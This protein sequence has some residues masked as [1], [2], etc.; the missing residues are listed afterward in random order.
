MQEL[1]AFLNTRRLCRG[2]DEQLRHSPSNGKIRY[3]EGQQQ[4]CTFAKSPLV[5]YVGSVHPMMFEL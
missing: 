1:Y 4:I 5:G 3:A 2:G